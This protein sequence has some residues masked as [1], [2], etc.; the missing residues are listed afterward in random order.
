[1]FIGAFGGSPL[2]LGGGPAGV[3]ELKLN[4]FAGAGVVEPTGADEDAVGVPN[5]LDPAGLFIPLKSPPDGG[6]AWLSNNPGVELPFPP[7]LGPKL[8]GVLD[9]AVVVEGVPNRLPVVP[10]EL[11]GFVAKVGVLP[12][13]PPKSDGVVP[14]PRLD[15]KIDP[16]CGVLEL[17]FAPKVLAP[18][19]LPPPKR[20]AAGFDVAVAGWP[21]GEDAVVVLPP[22][23]LLP[24][25]EVVLDVPNG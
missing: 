3:V 20:G 10:A 5:R 23:R 1:M 24:A 6:A 22:N 4:G 18:E 17:V 25:V 7:C 16:A 13:L 12:V 15:P 14:E 2:L 11:L 8:N 19:V 9:V 21:K